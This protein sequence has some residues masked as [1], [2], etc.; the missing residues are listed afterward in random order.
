MV[1]CFRKSRARVEGTNP[2]GRFL[3]DGRVERLT[4][5]IAHYS[6]RDLADQVDR[7]QSFSEI[8]H[9]ALL[10]EGR[11]ARVSDIVVRPFAR[12][13][14]G[15]VLKQGFRDG[16]PGFMIAAAS[17]FHVFLKYAKLWE[18]R[19]PEIHRAPPL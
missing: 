19:L 14:R 10:A 4:E 13:L 11:S 2:H 7:I 9:R 18:A 15:Y 3:V 1:R 12:F 6:Y 5:V 17:A 8:S 16:L